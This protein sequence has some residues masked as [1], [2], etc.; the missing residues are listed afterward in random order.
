MDN[1]LTVTLPSGEKKEYDIILTFYNEKTKKNY[2][3]FSEG[4]YD[5]NHKLIV[6]AQIYDNGIFEEIKTEEEWEEVERRLN[7]RSEHGI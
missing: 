5:D 3:V 2:F 6:Y 1:K 4:E 7:N